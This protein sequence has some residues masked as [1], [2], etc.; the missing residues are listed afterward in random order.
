MDPRLSVVLLTWNEEANIQACLAALAAQTDQ[1]FEVLVLDAA[2][3]DRTVA[4]VRE[5]QEGFPVPLRLEVAERRI[6]IGE[7]RN[8]G[9][10]LAKAPC[11][12]YVSADA[13]LDPD[14]VR[15]A[16]VSLEEADMVFGRQLH[17]PRTWTAAAAVRGLRYHFT[18]ARDIDPLRFASNVAAAY[19]REVLEMF[20]FDPWANAAEDVLLARR[21]DAA[22]Y[23]A[24]YNPDMLVRHHDVSTAAQEWRKNVREGEGC[25][26]YASELGLM[27]TVLA[28]GGAL[29]VCFA[30]TFLWTAQALLLGLALLWAPAIRRALQRRR[31]MPF[32]HLARG[33]AASPPYDLAFL[34]HYLRGLNR[35]RRLRS[36]KP[37]EVPA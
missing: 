3:T 33:V 20:P 15:Q 36:R 4:K 8:L 16:L 19:K 12:A 17:A 30:A 37:K 5:A 10:R 21:A 34:V 32:W 28:W 29:A 25:G 23:V 7:A 9:V 14:W 26:L 13:E 22:G 2:S 35:A 31:Q 1:R 18:E 27:P 11:I 24:V 6:P